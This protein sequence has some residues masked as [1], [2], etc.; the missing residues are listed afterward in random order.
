MRRR[1]K[2]RVVWLPQT[3]RNSFGNNDTVFQSVVG[4][5]SNSTGDKSQFEIPLV[6]DSPPQFIGSSTDP[7][8]FSLADIESSGYR[9]RRIVGKVWCQ[10]FSDSGSW[11]R[12]DTGPEQVIVTAGI[13]VR[14]ANNVSGDSYAVESTADAVDPQRIENAGDPWVWRRS[15]LLSARVNQVAT[16]QFTDL[17]EE[18]SINNWSNGYGSGVADGPHV[19]QKTARIVGAEDRLFLDITC[20]TLLEGLGGAEQTRQWQCVTDLRVLGSLKQSVGN[21]RNSSR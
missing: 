1:T 7:T 19:D 10:I 12:A 17:L 4:N 11:L 6:L 16:S 8:T 20:S 3:N 9:L 13:M 5:V 14:R 21:R 2:P 15:W 18:G